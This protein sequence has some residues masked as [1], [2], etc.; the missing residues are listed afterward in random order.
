MTYFATMDEVYF[1]TNSGGSSFTVD[2]LLSATNI[3]VYPDDPT[4]GIQSQNFANSVDG[5]LVWLEYAAA[6]QTWLVQCQ[7]T[8][9][10]NT[11]GAGNSP[12]DL[13]VFVVVGNSGPL[14]AFTTLIVT[15][16]GFDVTVGQS[17]TI[18]SSIT[19]ADLDQLV[20]SQPPTTTISLIDISVDSGIDGDFITNA[21]SQSITASLSRALATGETVW[22]S[23]DDGATWV[24]VTQNVTNTQISW[25]T[26]LLSGSGRAIVF[27]VRNAAGS[28]PLANQHYTLDTTAAAPSV[29]DL[30]AASDTGASSTDNLTA[31]TTPTVTG[32]GAEPGAT[33]TLY[34]TDGTTV[35]G[36]AVAAADGS[37]SITSSALADGA[38]TLSVRQT[39]LAGNQ[40]ALSAG[41]TVTIDTTAAAPSV[42]DLTAA[43]DTGASSTDNLTADTTPTVTG[44]G[45]EP[46]ATVTLYDTDGTTVL[47]SAVAAADG[48][49]SITSSVLADGARTLSVRQ[50]DLAG[51]QSV[52]SA[53]LTVTV[54]TTPP[55]SGGTLAFAS[56]VDTGALGDGIT[57]DNTFD[58]SLTGATALRYEVSTDGGSNWATTAAAQVGVADG[59]YQYRAVV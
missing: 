45:A 41:L 58:L 29:P 17:L 32:G 55:A 40:S 47:G 34:D 25:P 22:G 8:N 10:R 21:S 4:D 16:G 30:T 11:L 28:G 48:S 13:W 18:N 27:E 42:P 49:W 43:S 3:K 44:A 39:D 20:Q 38:H 50:T 56:L 23:V 51:N 1:G 35:L 6:G 36:S 14:P 37:W 19:M 7:L 24:N 26:T 57:S 5:A 31:D 54:D 59:S 46:G 15:S 53:G 9:G 33:V 2:A 12:E 52:L